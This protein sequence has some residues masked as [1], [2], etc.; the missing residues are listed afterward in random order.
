MNDTVKPEPTPGTIQA[1]SFNKAYGTLKAIAESMRS[2]TEPDID[3]LVPMVDKA[4]AAYTV[5]KA[6]I[7]S[8]KELL[9]AKLGNEIK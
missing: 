5:C 9:E 1:E 7:A 3:A 8:V 4:V 2:Q 6:R